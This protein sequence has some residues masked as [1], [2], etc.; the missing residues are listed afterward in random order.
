MKIPCNNL[1]MQLQPS[2]SKTQVNACNPKQL[3]LY[4]GR[5]LSS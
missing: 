3:R 1:R 2:V 5:L 4:R